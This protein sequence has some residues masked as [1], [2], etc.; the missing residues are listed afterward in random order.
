MRYRAVDSAGNFSRGATTN[1]TLAAASDAGA[2]GVRLASTTGRSAGDVLVID[3]GAGQETRDD[4]DDR[5]PRR[6][7]RP[8]RT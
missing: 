6:P 5:R 4:R 8:P 2:T 3:T 1:T 7:P